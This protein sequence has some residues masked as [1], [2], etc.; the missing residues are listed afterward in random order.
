[1]WAATR[2]DNE[3]LYIHAVEGGALCLAVSGYTFLLKPHITFSK[4]TNTSQNDFE[5]AQKDCVNYILHT[6]HTLRV[7]RNLRP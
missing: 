3:R 7:F 4:K 2:T 5:I 6:V 1:M